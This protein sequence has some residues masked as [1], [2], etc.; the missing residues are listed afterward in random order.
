MLCPPAVDREHDE[1]DLAA[2]GL[3]RLRGGE[4]LVPGRG[5]VLDER[6]LRNKL[7]YPLVQNH[8]GELIATIARALD[9]PEAP[10]WH[11]VAGAAKAVCETLEG[12]APIADQ[13]R[14]DAEALFAPTLELKAMATMRLV[15][16]VTR[17]TFAAVANPLALEADRQGAVA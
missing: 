1:P 8:L 17:Y 10:M 13:A 2:L 5:D 12:D 15:G 14:A 4:H 3:E 7:F 16:E 11:A 6:D 9:V